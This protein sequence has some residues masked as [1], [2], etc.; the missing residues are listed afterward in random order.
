MSDFESVAGWQAG[1]LCDGFVSPRIS[2]DW[3]RKVHNKRRDIPRTRNVDFVP[4]ETKYQL[5]TVKLTT[6]KTI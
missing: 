3:P 1:W 6:G 4:D 2:R 5:E